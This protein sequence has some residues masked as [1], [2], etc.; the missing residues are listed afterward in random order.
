MIKLISSDLDGTLLNKKG[1]LNPNLFELIKELRKK[2]ILFTVATGRQYANARMLFEPVLSDIIILAEN[3]AYVEYKDEVLFKNPISEY[4]LEK[5]KAA[6]KEIKDS[7]IFLCTKNTG[8]LDNNSER[9]ME[10]AKFYGII[11]K[12]AEDINS[13]DDEILKIAIADFNNAKLNTLPILKEKF[14]N[15]LEVEASGTVWVD[16][17]NKGISKGLAIKIIQDKFNIR[18]EETIAI[19]DNDNDLT[20][21][22]MVYYSY[23][24]K[25]S[26]TKLK[27]KAKFSAESN[28]NDGVLKIIKSV[29]N[30][31]FKEI[32]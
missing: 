10:I 1:E 11:Y 18:P 27:V 23:A 22:D 15:E 24:M 16:I 12:Y 4:Y 25:E 5:I 30:G 21:M 29:L 6:V 31:D 9:M 8:Y 19:G 26:S 20:M 28:E 32:L 7:A 14:S 2:D 13:V 17:T 3:G